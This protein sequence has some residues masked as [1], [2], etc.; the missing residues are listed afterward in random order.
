M[1]PWSLVA[2]PTVRLRSWLWRGAGQ[3]GDGPESQT[4]YPRG[5]AV[6]S[7]SSFWLQRCSILQAST[8]VALGSIKLNVSH[9]PLTQPLTVSLS[10][11]PYFVS[12]VLSHDHAT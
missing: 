2:G 3:L 8:A 4:S 11:R 9:N 10:R 7:L 12:L 6:A 5:T 1:P